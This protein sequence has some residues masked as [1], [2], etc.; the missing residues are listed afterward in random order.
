M[1]ATRAIVLALFACRRSIAYGARSGVR[2]PRALVAKS[3]RGV[4]AL[5]LGD[6][7]VDL[8]RDLQQRFPRAELHEAA[9]GP[10]VSRVVSLI[11][12]PASELD[13]SLDPQGSEFQLRVWNAAGTCA[14]A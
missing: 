10:V 4:C 14:T 5:L 7:A 8:L 6:D 13:V 11:A 12:A 9:L 3:E 2:N 1:R